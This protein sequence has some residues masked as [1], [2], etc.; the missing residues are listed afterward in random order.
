M[1]KK[2]LGKELPMKF[3]LIIADQ[4]KKMNKKKNFAKF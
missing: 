3:Y 4:D 1:R 2:N